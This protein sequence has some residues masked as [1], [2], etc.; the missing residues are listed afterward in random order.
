M[1]FCLI[2]RDSQ[3][4]VNLLANIVHQNQNRPTPSV[5]K[6]RSRLMKGDASP[7]RLRAQKLEVAEEMKKTPQ[8][9]MG[10]RIY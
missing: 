5:I 1:Y 10:K 7:M 6:K 3:R 9:R 8:I 2:S 4:S